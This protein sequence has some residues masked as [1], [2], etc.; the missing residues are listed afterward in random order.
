[1]SF[2]SAFDFVKEINVINKKRKS[3]NAAIGK[4]IKR[5]AVQSP[6]FIFGKTIPATVHT[7]KATADKANSDKSCLCSSVSFRLIFY[8][9]P[10]DFFVL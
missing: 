8:V 1:M 9:P 2:L 6:L 10:F 3:K 5:L 4:H 7:G